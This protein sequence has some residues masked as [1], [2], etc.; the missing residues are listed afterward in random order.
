MSNVVVFPFTTTR[1]DARVV[2]LQGVRDRIYLIAAQLDTVCAALSE[3]SV[4]REKSELS[5][6]LH[7][8]KVE[9]VPS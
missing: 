2:E 5:F 9:N 3:Q 6:G 8:K 7:A 1:Q 4:G